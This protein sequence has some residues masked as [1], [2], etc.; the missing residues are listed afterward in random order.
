MLTD[1]VRYL[2]TAPFLAIFPGV[3]IVIS[4][5]GFNLIGDGL[6]EALDPK[7]RGRDMSDTAAPRRRGPAG[8][9]LDEPRAV[10]AVNGDLVRHRAGRDARHR[11]RVGLRQERH[12]ARAARDP[13]ARG[14]RHRGQ[15]RLDGRELTALSRRAAAPDPRQGDRD[16]LPGPDDEPEPG[17]HDRAADPRG[18]R[19]APRP[20]PQGARPARAVEL[21]DQ[22][23][24]P[25]R[26]GRG[27]RTTRTSSR[28]ACGSA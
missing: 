28:A 26:E 14:P 3:A 17:A 21:L 18:A 8:P 13:A 24:I 6:R 9:L 22:V 25:E 11:R 20:G 4:V 23:G 1:T 7:L 10:H 19:D 5:L 15:R 16:D 2:Q 27:C 12:R